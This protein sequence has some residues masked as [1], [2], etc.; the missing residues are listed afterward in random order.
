MGAG[1]EE[2]LGIYRQHR[3][4]KTS[5]ELSLSLQIFPVVCSQVL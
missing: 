4:K 2:D 5:L 1:L 3:Q